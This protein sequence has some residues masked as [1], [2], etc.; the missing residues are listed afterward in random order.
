GTSS[1]RPSTAGPR[2]LLPE[3]RK[4]LACDSCGEAVD[5]KG[6]RAARCRCPGNGAEGARAAQHRRGLE[7][8]AAY[9][10]AALCRC[11]SNTSIP[12]SSPPS[13]CPTSK[14]LLKTLGADEDRYP[15]REVQY[16][17]NAQKEEGVRARDVAAVDDSSRRFVELYAAY[18]E[19]CQRE[20]VVDFAELLL[21]SYELLSRNEIL[22]EHYSRRFRHIL[23]DEFQDTNRL[24][25]RWLKL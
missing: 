19:Q 14:R 7:G 23:V 13:R 11:T 21:R 20:G 16:F 9:I 25:Y 22:R 2:A 12:N 8:E 10:I 3:D 24:Q 6:Q 17:I 18:D 4:V 15:P 1:F 5:Y